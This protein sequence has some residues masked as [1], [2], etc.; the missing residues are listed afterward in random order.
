MLEQNKP[1]PPDDL[2]ELVGLTREEWNKMAE[3]IQLDAL[4]RDPVIMEAL[5][6]SVRRRAEDE[7]HRRI[8]PYRKPTTN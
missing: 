1:Y 5:A 7:L 2:L 3:E 6:A 4:K 8:E